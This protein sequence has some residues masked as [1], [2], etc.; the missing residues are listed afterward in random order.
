LIIEIADTDYETD[1][2]EICLNKTF[3]FHT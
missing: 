3:L 1:Y 2:F